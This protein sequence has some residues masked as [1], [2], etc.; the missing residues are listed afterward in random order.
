MH[1]IR[2]QYIPILLY[3]SNI[4]STSVTHPYCTLTPTSSRVKMFIANIQNTHRKHTKLVTLKNSSFEK[5]SE[6]SSW[7]H[8]PADK[9]WSLLILQYLLCLGEKMVLGL[10]SRSLSFSR[11]FWLFGDR[12]SSSFF[13]LLKRSRPVRMMCSSI[14]RW[15]FM[16]D[17]TLSSRASLFTEERAEDPGREGGKTS[18]SLFFPEYNEEKKH[19]S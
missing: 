2:Q 17:S 11:S 16:S 15:R 3:P 8:L 1:C 12:A 7:P 18:L 14:L 19:H 4:Y 9:S 5:A 10:L 6:S 13:S